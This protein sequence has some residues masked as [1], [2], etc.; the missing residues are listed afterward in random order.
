MK[1]AAISD[2]HGLQEFVHIEQCDILC[3]CGDI[4]PLKMQR[5]IPQSLSWFKKQFIPWCEKQPC[6]Q[7]Y[8]VAGNHDFFLERLEREI[9]DVLKGT[10]IIYLNNQ[11][12]EYLDENTGKLYILW[13]SPLCHIFGSWA[14]MYSPEYELEEFNKMPENCDIV[15][16]HDAPYGI[17]DI[18][19]QGWN[20]EHI[21]NH[22]LRKVIE[23]K[24][25]KLLLHGH[26]HSTNH[27]CE[28]LNNTDVYNVSVVD[29]LYNI[30]YKPLYLEL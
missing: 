23:E 17:S 13:G 22:E 14:F 11:S 3:I 24:N 4:V 26:L 6:E 20:K 28:T 12:A 10:K 30:T 1:I 9:N 21:G 2:M 5:N 18:C 7:I 25:P 16:V 15:L 19:F 27:E 8:L 29:E